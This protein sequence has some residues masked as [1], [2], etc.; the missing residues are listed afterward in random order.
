MLLTNIGTDVRSYYQK[1]VPMVANRI[2]DGEVFGFLSALDSISEN[3]KWSWQRL[4]DRIA[5]RFFDGDLSD[6]NILLTKLSI[7][8]K[9]FYMSYFLTFLNHAGVQVPELTYNTW[10]ANMLRLYDVITQI[11]MRL[12]EHH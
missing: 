1:D 7:S 11:K 9:L 2:A 8:G 6:L 10:S 12:I 3:M 5:S 4:F